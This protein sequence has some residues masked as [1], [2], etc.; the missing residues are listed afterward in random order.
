MHTSYADMTSQI[1]TPPR[2]WDANG[3]PRYVPFSPHLCPDIYAEQVVLL[4]ITCQECER[5]FSVA[6]HGSLWAAL[7]H[8]RTLHYGDPPFHGCIGDTMNC[9]DRVVLQVWA[10]AIGDAWRRRPDLE[11]VIPPTREVGQREPVVWDTA[12]HGLRDE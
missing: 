1:A 9:T 5:P 3:V 2:W 8:P 7:P 6:L 12:A 11:G 10:R 4:G